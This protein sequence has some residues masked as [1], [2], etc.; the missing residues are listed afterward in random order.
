MELNTKNMKKIMLL[1][2]FTIAVFWCGQYFLKISNFIF[3]FL[4]LFTPLFLGFAIAFVL[5]VFMKG[6]EKIWDRFF[7]KQ[8]NILVKIKRPISVAIT[9]ILVIAILNILL[10]MVVPEISR[11]ISS[12]VEMLPTYMLEL[13]KNIIHLIDKYQINFINLP[14][15]EIDWDKL[16][17]TI[18]NFLSEGGKSFFSTTINITSSIFSGV[19]SF[20]L[21]LVFSIYMLLQKEKLSMQ[22]K[23]ILYAFLPIKAVK[24][25]LNVG[26][27][28]NRVF[29][30]FVTGQMLEAIIFGVLCFIGMS[31]LGLPYSVMISTL[32]GFTA[33]I[34][35]VGAFIGTGIGAF[36]ILLIN[37]MQA[38]W[39]VIFIIILQQIEGN[40]IYPRVV[41]QSVGLPGIWV[42]TA[43]TIG[44]SIGGILGMLLSVPI[45]SILYII[46]K[47]TVNYQLE[48]KKIKDV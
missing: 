3:Y 18:G 24:E 4:G 35:I 7:T 15:L 5:N 40:L 13:E 29:S 25:I 34:P 17:S 8:N 22:F 38:L 33:L 45:C 31:I 47:N 43:V 6:I 10:F 30:N 39:F 26:E 48:K 27:I 1:I 21:G 23:K 9:F 12:I 19:V 41:G 42:L 44:G 28:A 16:T 2:L 14:E 46:L 32:V 11:S 36:L 20:V 37:P